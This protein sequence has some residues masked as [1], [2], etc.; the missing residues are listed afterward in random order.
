MNQDIFGINAGTIGA[1]YMTLVLFGVGYNALTAW[2]EKNDFMHGYTAF[3]VVGGVFVTVALTGFFNLPFAILV[4]G[5]FVASGT[6]MI[7]GSMVRHKLAERRQALEQAKDE[8][9][10]NPA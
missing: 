3:F 1:V 7:I 4:A 9:H 5:A 2:A 6:P 10:G 8:A